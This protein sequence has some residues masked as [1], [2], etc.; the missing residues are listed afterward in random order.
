MQIRKRWKGRGRGEPNPSS[1]VIKVPSVGIRG[2]GG[3]LNHIAH[4]SFLSP[5]CRHSSHIYEDVPCLFYRYVTTRGDVRERG[6]GGEGSSPL[7][8]RKRSGV[9]RG[10]QPVDRGGRDGG[11]RRGHMTPTPPRRPHHMSLLLLMRNNFLWRR[12]LPNY[13]MRRREREDGGEGD[14]SLPGYAYVDASLTEIR[15]R[16]VGKR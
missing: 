3:S 10:S 13:R 4:I 2:G 12:V 9:Q 14:F 7:P 11:R 16:R 5:P 6:D 15:E 1:S 8:S